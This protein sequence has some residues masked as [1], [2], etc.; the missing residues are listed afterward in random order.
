MCIT[1]T[2]LCGQV[3]VPTAVTEYV[4]TLLQRGEL[5]TFSIQLCKQT[6]NFKKLVGIN[7]VFPYVYC[8]TNALFRLDGNQLERN[9]IIKFI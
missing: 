9:K 4:P 3:D 6:E 5:N 2:D 7:N 8:V 1:L